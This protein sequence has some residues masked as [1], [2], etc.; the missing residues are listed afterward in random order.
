MCKNN[1]YKCWFLNT[2]GEVTADVGMEIFGC[3]PAVTVREVL[4]PY[5]CSAFQPTCRITQR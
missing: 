2:S 1:L 4:Y 5:D 3:S